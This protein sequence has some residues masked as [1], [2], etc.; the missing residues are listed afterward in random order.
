MY[1][2]ELNIVTRADFQDIKTR[3]FLWLL[4]IQTFSISLVR[5]H[6]ISN[7]LKRNKNSLKN[8]V[9]QLEVIDETMQEVELLFE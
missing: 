5:S 6:E 4:E 1:F 3:A 9:N 7:L 2:Y 8:L